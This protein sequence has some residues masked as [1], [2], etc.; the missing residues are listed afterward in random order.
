MKI[1]NFSICLSEYNI[2]I[3][4]F[5]S[6]HVNLLF[7]SRHSTNVK[8]LRHK[9]KSD[10]LTLESKFPPPCHISAAVEMK[11][12]NMLILYGRPSPLTVFRFQENK[13]RNHKLPNRNVQIMNHH[14]WSIARDVPRNSIIFQTLVLSVTKTFC[15]RNWYLIV[16]LLLFHINEM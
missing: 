8:W 11:V 7:S 16:S 10:T 2:W 13:V 4:S 12:G 14:K 15:W 6:L 3:F 1:D 5:E 9:M